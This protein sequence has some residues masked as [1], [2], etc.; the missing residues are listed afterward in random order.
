MPADDSTPTFDP[1]YDPV[2]QRGYGGG[3]DAGA[4]Q[5]SDAVVQTATGYA[6][7]RGASG[8]AGDGRQA[9]EGRGRPA[10][11]VGAVALQMPTTEPVRGVDASAEQEDD[12]VVDLFDQPDGS[13]ISAGV[14]RMPGWWPMLT[15]WLVGV[16]LVLVGAFCLANGVRFNLDMQ[17]GVEGDSPILIGYEVSLALVQPALIVGLATLVSAV[18]LHFIVPA[19]R[20]HR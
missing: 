2:F 9:N 12:D 1:R 19:R 3:P 6:I 15:L 5:P 8:A 18:A 7:G 17:S 14:R 13:W 4:S 10:R 20:A 11:D 16:V